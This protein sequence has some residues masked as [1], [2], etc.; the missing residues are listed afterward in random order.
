MESVATPCA[1]SVPWPMFAAPS[2]KTTLPV[3]VPVGLMTV[4]VSVT[5]LP[6]RELVPPAV[7]TVVVEVDEI[8]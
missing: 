4:T 1:L 7:S 5:G 8:D 2:R 3:G 6:E